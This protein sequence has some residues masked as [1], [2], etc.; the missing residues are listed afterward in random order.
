MVLTI[1]ASQVARITKFIDP[2]LF[3]AFGLPPAILA[4]G[5]P[6]DTA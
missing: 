2:G 4:G 6:A 3:A 1:A 5:D